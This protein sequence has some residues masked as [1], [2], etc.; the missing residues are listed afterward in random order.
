MADVCHRFGLAYERGDG[1]P[2]DYET[3]F[4]WHWKS[5][6]L[7]H[8]EARD[9]L[10]RC[11]ARTRDANGE[12]RCRVGRMHEHGLAGAPRNA[13]RACEWYARAAEHGHAWARRRRERLLGPARPPWW[14][15]LRDRILRRPASGG[16]A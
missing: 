12:I 1:V 11:A 10:E 9:A 16:K 14:R 4:E 6:L 13:A 5:A 2:L 3:A 15:R 7:G 8:A